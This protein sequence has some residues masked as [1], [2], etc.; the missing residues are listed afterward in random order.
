MP[1]VEHVHCDADGKIDELTV[2]VRPLSGGP[3]VA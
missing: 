2:M 3:R 1:A